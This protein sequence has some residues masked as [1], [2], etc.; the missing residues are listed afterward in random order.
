ILKEPSMQF[1]STLTAEEL[2]KAEVYWVKTIQEEGFTEAISRLRLSQ[3]PQQKD[4]FIATKGDAEAGATLALLGEDKLCA[5]R[6]ELHSEGLEA[7]IEETICSQEQLRGSHSVNTS[8]EATAPEAPAIE[9]T[10]PGRAFTQFD[11]EPGDSDD[12]QR[13]GD[14]EEEAEAQKQDKF[15]QD[16]DRVENSFEVA[17]GGNCTLL[18]NSMF[19]RI[20][21]RSVKS[22][23]E[24]TADSSVSVRL[25]SEPNITPAAED[26]VSSSR[27]LHL[28]SDKVSRSSSKSAKCSVECE[29]QCAEDTEVA[30]KSRIV[31][32]LESASEISPKGTDIKAN[33]QLLQLMVEKRDNVAIVAPSTVNPKASLT[34]TKYAPGG[35]RAS[36]VQCHLRM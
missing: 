30:R 23:A 28:E 5:T 33:S 12:D 16:Q 2:E 32:L 26:S 3:V 25:I 27:A 21:E 4:V 31:T 29:S 11:D 15:S 14:P 8:E 34:T 17:N 35:T 7:V 13:P 9:Q 18:V 24:L 1:G 36:G 20:G 19:G 6:E 22:G 10:Q